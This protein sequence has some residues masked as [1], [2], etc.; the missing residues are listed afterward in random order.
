MPPV[1]TG[2]AVGPS[3]S[4]KLK[5]GAMMGGTVGVI[6][7]FIYGTVNIFRYGAGVNGIM[8]TLGQYMAASG[9]TFGFFMS[10]G[11]VIRS[12]SS[13][14]VQEAY[15]NARRRPWIMAAETA[16]RPR[17]NRTD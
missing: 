1:S 3:T 13:P 4:D 2:H 11:S 9:A 14:I 16:Y 7:G 10:I 8:R 17:P 5:M 12:D 6:I 15:A